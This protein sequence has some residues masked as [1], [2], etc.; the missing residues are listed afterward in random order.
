MCPKPSPCFT[1]YN[2][3]NSENFIGFFRHHSLQVMLGLVCK[4]DLKRAEKMT[5]E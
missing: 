1:P 5:A 4:T 3:R 2:S